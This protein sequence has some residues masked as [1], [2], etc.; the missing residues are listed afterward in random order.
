MVIYIV[1]NCGCTDCFPVEI[2]K[3]KKEAIIYAEKY[4]TYNPEKYTI[5]KIKID[6]FKDIKNLFHII[7]N[8]YK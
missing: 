2:F 7:N 4:C 8:S 1:N 5:N 6:S 3:N